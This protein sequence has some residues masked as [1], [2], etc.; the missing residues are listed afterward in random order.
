MIHLTKN[1]Q[2]FHKLVLKE[3]NIFNRENMIY[4]DWLGREYLLESRSR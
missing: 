3:K 1:V 2:M 4:V